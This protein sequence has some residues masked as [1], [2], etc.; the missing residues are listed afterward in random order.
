[1]KDLRT[2]DRAGAPNNVL[3]CVTKGSA[4]DGHC[5]HLSASMRRG[6]AAGPRCTDQNCAAEG[7]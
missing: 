4:R 5:G 2:E 7:R 3:R 6:G 1:M